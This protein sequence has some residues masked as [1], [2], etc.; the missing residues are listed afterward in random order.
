MPAV[1][2]SPQQIKLWIQ[3]FLKEDLGK[4]DI[5]SQSTLAEDVS[6]EAILIAK[7]AGVVAG[8]HIARQ[9]FLCV[10]S[11]LRVKVFVKD[12]DRIAVGQELLSVKGKAVSIFAAERLALNILGHLCGIATT[13]AEFVQAMGK[14]QSIL[15]DTRKTLPGLR[16]LERYAVTVGGG[17]NHRDRLDSAVLI[18]TNH[19]RVLE[20]KFGSRVEAI[21]IALSRARKKCSRKTIEIEVANYSEFEAALQAV[22]DII[23]LD[24]WK[25]QQIVKAVKWR[26]YVCRG[27]AK[28]LL[29]I[30]GGIT[31]K[32]IARYAACGA[33]RISVGSLTHSAKNLDVSLRVS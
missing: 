16:S 4:G 28:V 17:T 21:P 8:T 3:D 14:T 13:T 23:L 30:S 10:N 31:L 19:L 9:V 22:P 12:G 20:K 26:D 18:K 24:N 15:L 29:E 5:T 32:T 6:I 25:P 27:K 2:L 33:D 1:N 11:H 7:E